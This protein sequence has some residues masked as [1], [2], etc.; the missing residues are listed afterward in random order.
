MK[1][2][3]YKELSLASELKKRA[4]VISSFKLNLNQLLLLLTCFLTLPAI[5][6]YGLI[7][8]DRYVSETTFVVR[9]LSTQKTTSFGAFLESLG[10]IPTDEEVY[11][12]Q[13]FIL[14]RDA[15][16][17]LSRELDIKNIYGNKNIDLF[18]KYPRFWV[19]NNQTFERLYEYYLDHISAIYDPNKGITKLSVTTFN[20]KDSQKIAKTLLR[21]SEETINKMNERAFKDAISWSEIEKN[22]AEKLLLEAQ[23]NL[24]NFRGQEGIVDPS[25]ETDSVS[26]TIA[27]LYKG[28]TDM[29]TTKSG[30]MIISPTNPSVGAISSRVEAL[31]A[32]IRSQRKSLAG[33]DESLSRK[34]EEYEKLALKQAIAQQNLSNA[35]F[36][37]FGAKRDAAKHRFYLEMISEPNMPDAATEPKSIRNILTALCVALNTSLIIWFLITG[38]REH[39]S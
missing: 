27:E 34:I 33:G 38:A 2:Y 10:L 29:E 17:L 31:K 19:S 6:Y 3:Y 39:S 36:S 18:A 1:P 15:L 30:S 11:A 12:V 5:I 21:L 7:A 9:S 24:L 26:K 16:E 23:V 13:N 20:P 32:Q 37:F 4:N 35:T 28:L 22:T 8:T 14:S 25:Q